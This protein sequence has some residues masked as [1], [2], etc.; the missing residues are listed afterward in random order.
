MLFRSVRQMT[1]AVHYI[2][3]FDRS[4]CPADALSDDL[5]LTV[6]TRSVSYGSIP[7]YISFCFPQFVDENIVCD[8]VRGSSLAATPSRS[9]IAAAG[10]AMEILCAKNPEPS[11]LIDA[12]FLR[13]TN[14]FDCAEFTRP[15]PNCHRKGKTQN[16][17]WVEALEVLRDEVQH[18]PAQLVYSGDQ[19]TQEPPLRPEFNSCGLAFGPDGG[20]HARLHALLE[21]I[22]RDA[23]LNA[24]L[25][26]TTLVRIEGEPQHLTSTLR[27]LKTQGL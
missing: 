4:P 7:Y 9:R 27:A 22:E 14:R 18:V 8:G 21:L 16:V 10:E 2:T 3:E 23:S 13:K 19:F 26:C 15:W 6:A 17:M 24:F 1:S 25:N 11:R 20:D 12:Q 5:G